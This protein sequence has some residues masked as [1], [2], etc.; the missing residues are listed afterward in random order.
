MTMNCN[1]QHMRAPEK[2]SPPTP[3]VIKWWAGLAP[4]D[5]P[6][7]LAKRY[8]RVLNNIVA[9]WHDPARCEQVLSGLIVDTERYDRQGFPFE[10]V[11]ELLALRTLRQ[12]AEAAAP[13]HRDGEFT[14]D[15]E[16]G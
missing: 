11:M 9:Q 15:G 14:F 8:P 7:H 2:P 4:Q 3:A 6:L 16:H 10:I 5:R 13:A 12:Q 1:P